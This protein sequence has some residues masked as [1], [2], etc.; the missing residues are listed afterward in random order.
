MNTT[1]AK[2]QPPSIL[3]MGASGSG[4]TYSIS[5]LLEAGLNVFV[6]STEPHGLD[7]LLDVVAERKLDLAKL[8][9]T[10]VSPARPGFGKLADMAKLIS[11][12]DQR[13]L[14]DTKPG[15]R[16]D[17]GFIHML[18]AFNNFI[19]QK[20]GKSYGPV[21]NLGADSVL[22]VD[23]LSGVS[24]MAMDLVVG[25]KVTAHPGEWGIAMKQIDKFLLSCTA[26][27]SCYFVMIAHV[28][29]EEDLITGAQ[30]VMVSTLG[31]KLAPNIPK[32]FSEVVLAEA[33]SE[34]GDRKSFRWSTN[35]ANHVLK[36]RALPISSSLDPSFKPIVEAH[37]RRLAAISK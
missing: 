31:K 18:N 12:A 28:E 3:L 13:T 37:N 23:S 14:A 11:I 24:S 30:Q 29:K 4:K 7:T 5:T 19:D 36:N 10:Y 15:A 25:D 32:F 6:V 20:D 16:S 2:L 21:T 22:V 9:Y 34:Q 33:R 8:H 35:T 1:P 27:L 17:A 26:D